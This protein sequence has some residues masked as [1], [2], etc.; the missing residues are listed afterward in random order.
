VRTRLALVSAAVGGALAFGSMLISAP[1]FPA[2]A[3]VTC[4]D[5]TT[6]ANA[7]S[8]EVRNTTTDLTKAQ[9][10]LKTDQAALDALISK[11][12]PPPAD[13][14]AITTAREL[15]AADQKAV[16]DATA[17]NN[18]A[19]A[20]FNDAEKARVAAC[21]GTAP[22][23]RDDTYSTAMNTNLIIGAPGILA[24]DS[25]ADGD[26]LASAVIAG[27][28][29]G[30]VSGAG[31]GSFTYVPTTNYVGP[32]QFTYKACDPVGKCDTATVFITVKT[33]G[34]NG[35]GNGNGTPGVPAQFGNC[36]QAARFGFHDIP[37]TNP[38]YR[39]IL[40]RDRDGI[41][42]EL[43]EGPAPAVVVPGPQGPAGPQG[44]QGPVGPSGTTTGNGSTNV[45]VVPP[46]P[47][48]SN[49]GQIGQ[50]PA[51][52]AATGFGPNA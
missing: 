30:N 3:A 46:A 17:A 44:P 25:D 2:L 49:F 47:S 52:A 27:A 23:A 11:T 9:D 20:K 37:S 19:V 45:I 41:A 35:N 34:N 16:T 21:A 10:K 31:N 26:P 7:A 22:V 14:T 42:C 43:N 24:N 38:R 48:G 5:A 39:L 36:A 15:V 33:A 13:Q 28:Q 29:H 18:T 51:G 1:A 32:D 50:A 8:T 4:A 6:A 12:D 40:D